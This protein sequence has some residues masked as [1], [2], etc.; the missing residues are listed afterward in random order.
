MGRLFAEYV[1]E[2]GVSA[3]KSLCAQQL[4]T[5][6]SMY[7]CCAKLLPVEVSAKLVQDP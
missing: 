6:I 1:W 7:K 4:H 5:S 3:T 2:E